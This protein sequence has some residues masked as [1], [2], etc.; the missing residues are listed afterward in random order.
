[1]VTFEFC[2]TTFLLQIQHEFFYFVQIQHYVFFIS[3]HFLLLFNNFSFIFLVNTTSL[4]FIA[5]ILS[6]TKFFLV[7]SCYCRR[8]FPHIFHRR[9]MQLV[10]KRSDLAYVDI[11]IL[12]QNTSKFNHYTC[13]HTITPFLV[14]DQPK[15]KQEETRQSYTKVGKVLRFKRSN[16][17][18]SQPVNIL[19]YKQVAWDIP[20]V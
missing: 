20:I 11:H 14:N 15:H 10:W 3:G 9:I 16:Y 1:M 8:N 13:K 19:A 7:Y 17:N 6:I 12:Y 4:L 18:D 2:S 5:Y